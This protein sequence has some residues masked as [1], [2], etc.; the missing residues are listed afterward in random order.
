MEV[1]NRYPNTKYLSNDLFEEVA[2]EL[3]A[4]AQVNHENASSKSKVFLRAY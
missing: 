4:D 1:Q 2:K 3:L